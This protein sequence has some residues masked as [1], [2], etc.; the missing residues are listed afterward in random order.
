MQ[1]NLSPKLALIICCAAFL[2]SQ[3]RAQSTEDLARQDIK[4]QVNR[5]IDTTMKIVGDRAAEFNVRIAAINETRPLELQNFDSTRVSANIS[6][7][8]EF[9]DYLAWI[10]TTDDSLA[11]G[12]EDSLF[13]IQGE[14]PPESQDQKALEAF[15]ESYAA[16]RKAFDT[17]VVTLRKLYS[18]VL[19]VLLFM[20]HADYKI[21]NN[22]L[23]FKSSND[24]AKYRKLMKPIDATSKE[25][26]KASDL[27]RK[28]TEWANQKIAE[29][30]GSGSPRP[31]TTTHKPK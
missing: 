30:N 7:I 5:V 14:I 13:I 20:Q 16:D 10:R 9:V 6:R 29:I 4:N 23:Q 17:Y 8:L 1:I 19:N 26:K 31:Q 27:S 11:R 3:A 12:L 28:A 25:L 22:Q 24:I 15:Q 21:D 2:G 18:E